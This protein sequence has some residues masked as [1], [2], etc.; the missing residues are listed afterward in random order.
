MRPS[1]SRETRRPGVEETTATPTPRT[2]RAQTNGV[3]QRN[4]IRI[5]YRTSTRTRS[6]IRIRIRNRTRTRSRARWRRTRT[7]HP[8]AAAGAPRRSHAARQPLPAAR[9][10]QRC[11]GPHPPRQ[12]CVSRLHRREVRTRPRMDA[13]AIRPHD[14]SC[15]RIDRT[16]RGAGDHRVVACCRE[17]RLAAVHFVVH[18]DPAGSVRRHPRDDLVAPERSADRL[19]QPIDHGAHTGSTAPQRQADRVHRRGGTACRL[20]APRQHLGAGPPPSTST[21]AR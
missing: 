16:R 3:H 10:D 9:V 1:R 19:A 12:R 11:G 21:R 4:R 15:R 14:S 18:G 20:R 6:R 8:A 17:G 2:Q 7:H 5:S 13:H